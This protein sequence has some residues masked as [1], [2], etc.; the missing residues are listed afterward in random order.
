[1]NKN[2]W[3]MEM[4]HLCVCILEARF[5][6]KDQVEKA[7]THFSKKSPSIHHYEQFNSFLADY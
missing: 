7:G 5:F 2:P 4:P 1:M 3:V 6:M